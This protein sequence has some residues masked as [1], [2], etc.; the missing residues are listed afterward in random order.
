[1]GF[2]TPQ[3]CNNL[4]VFWH[5]HSAR[6]ARRPCAPPSHQAHNV[7]GASSHERSPSSLRRLSRAAR[8][9]FPC[10]RR[11]LPNASL[12]VP[13]MTSVAS[14]LFSSSL[15]MP[16]TLYPMDISAFDR[17]ESLM[18]LPS[19]SWKARLWYSTST[20]SCGQQRSHR[21]LR[22]PAMDT[23]DEEAVTSYQSKRAT[24]T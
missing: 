20:R 15:V 3:I 7:N 22:R 1:M 19:P 21:K 6:L 24:K 4:R 23:A 2:R 12:M 9:L 11:R 16:M 17:R 8:A 14:R 5:E 18:R 10:L 13:A